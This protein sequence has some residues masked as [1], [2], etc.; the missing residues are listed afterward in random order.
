MTNEMMTN[1]MMTKEMLEKRGFTFVDCRGGYM[2]NDDGLIYNNYC[3]FGYK[4]DIKKFANKFNLTIISVEKFLD[5]EARFEE[6]AT[7]EQWYEMYDEYM[8]ETY[9]WYGKH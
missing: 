6:Y 9:D 4:R 8:K 3:Q 7:R 2:I 1:E 5:Y